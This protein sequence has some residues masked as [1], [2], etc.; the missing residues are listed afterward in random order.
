MQWARGIPVLA[1]VMAVPLM[2]DVWFSFLPV[3]TTVPVEAYADPLSAVA[4]RLASLTAAAVILA[5]Y[6]AL[7]RGPD[8]AVLDVHPVRPG[9]LVT[10]IALATARAQFYLVALAAVLLLPVLQA[11]SLPAYLGA[12]GLVFSAWAGALGV[13]F[14]VHLG[15]VWAAYSPALE[16]VLDAL[17]GDNPRMQ[18]ALIYAP[19]VALLLVG[20]GVEFGSMG[21]AAWLKGWTPGLFWLVIPLALGVLAWTTV[22]SLSRRFYVRASLLL[23]EVDGAWARAEEAEQAGAVYLQRWAEG[24]PELLRA[25]RNG[26]RAQRIYATGSWALGALLV[27]IGWND[28]GAAAFWGAGAVVWVTGISSQLAV[29]DPQWLDDAL[30]VSP[31]AVWGA[32]SVVAF[33]YAMGVVAPVAAMLLV[34]H[35]S[36]GLIVSL[37]LMGLSVAGAWCGAGVAHLWR[38]QAQWAYGAIALVAW[39]GFVRV[40][41]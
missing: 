30:G 13:G 12:L 16:S 29:G 24:R 3:D 6:S 17:R 28:P 41:G 10:A 15:G 5:S 18:A 20:G 14:M 4:G 31:R 38:R 11:G 25:L 36:A 34:R 2:R 9:M 40:L 26:W 39:A 27:V 37:G 1:A 35:G 23:A 8:R 7:V 22:G 33:S 32:R 19:G 21:L